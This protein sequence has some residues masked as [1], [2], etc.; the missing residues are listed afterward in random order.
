MAL[1]VS[2]DIKITIA[3]LINS[4]TKENKLSNA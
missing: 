4:K 3:N 1:S 2:D